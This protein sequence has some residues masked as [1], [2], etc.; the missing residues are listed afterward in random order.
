[1][2]YW[3]VKQQSIGLEIQQSSGMTVFGVRLSR[4]GL[5]FEDG[6]REEVGGGATIAD[7]YSFRV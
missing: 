4:A 2:R 7:K 5:D 3:M 1:M 6:G